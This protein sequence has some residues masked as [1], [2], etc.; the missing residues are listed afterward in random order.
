MNQTRWPYTTLAYAQE[1]VHLHLLKLSL[2]EDF[3]LQT[4]CFSHLGGFLREGI[5]EVCWHADSERA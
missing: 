3:E 2:F 4:S 1:K 5:R